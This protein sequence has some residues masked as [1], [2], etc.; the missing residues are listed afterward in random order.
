MDKILVVEKKK[1]K[2]LYVSMKEALSVVVLCDGLTDHQFCLLSYP[3]P[4]YLFKY[5]NYRV[6]VNH[7]CWV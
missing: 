7:Y 2:S 4:L 1:R 3:L 6:I 5:T